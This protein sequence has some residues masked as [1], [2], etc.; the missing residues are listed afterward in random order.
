MQVTSG[1]KDIESLLVRLG[2]SLLSLEET[3]VYGHDAGVVFAGVIDR[4][5][6]SKRSLWVEQ[7]V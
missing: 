3:S 7:V 1:G 2:E 4:V 5:G 6:V